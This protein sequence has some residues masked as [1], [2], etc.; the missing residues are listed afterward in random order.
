MNPSE[1]LTFYQDEMK[2]EFWALDIICKN[3]GEKTPKE[4]VEEYSKPYEMKKK[5]NN[6]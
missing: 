1:K 3:E 4:L 5:A 2:M 6:L